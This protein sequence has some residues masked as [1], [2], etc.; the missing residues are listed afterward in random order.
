VT[1]FEKIKICIKPQELVPLIC[2]SFS[3]KELIR[4]LTSDGFVYPGIRMESLRCEELAAGW[5]EDSWKDEGILGR[6][7]KALDKAHEEDLRQMRSV[8]LE[9]IGRMMGSVEEIWQQ[10]RMGGFLWALLRDERVDAEM[11]RW[12]LES[13]YCLLDK[14]DAK[15]RKREHSSARF[16]EHLWN[17]RLTKKE[18]EKVREMLSRLV[19]ENQEIQKTFNRELKDKAKVY[20]KLEDFKKKTQDGERQAGL[21]RNELAALRNESERKDALIRE[22]EHTS[23]TIS[24][25]QENM[26]RQRVHDLERDERKMQHEISELN[27]E[28]AAL[29]DEMR[30]KDSL[31]RELQG[32]LQEAL[33]QKERLEGEMK[34]LAMKINIRNEAAS[35]ATR[36]AAVTLKD[37][38]RRLGVFVDTRYLR[39]AC[40]LLQKKVDFQKLLDLAVVDRRLV[41]VAAYVMTAPE[42][43]P[44][45]FLKMLEKEGFQTRCRSFQRL[46]DGSVH[47]DWRAGIAVDV[48]N[49]SEKLNL[50]VIH[51][52]SGDGDFTDLIRFLQ[53]KGI[54]AEASGF[55]MNSATELV[56]AADEFVFLGEEVLK[57]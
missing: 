54:R 5:I 37:K 31:G 15:L 6:L 18:T 4:I 44:G 28:L 33:S 45:G 2:E 26:L 57:S 47:G 52:V 11:F 21:L 39:Q 13:F 8:P 46:A 19:M 41:K 42:V 3:Q 29:R 10:R 32:R 48:I 9:E 20:E 12:F 25:D 24:R 51:L 7:V 43:D 23:K 40:R 16:E 35:V 49:L 22:L 34:R 38:G 30:T 53:A 50:D 36:K 27:E 14:Q 56:Q 55:S 17:G 1:P